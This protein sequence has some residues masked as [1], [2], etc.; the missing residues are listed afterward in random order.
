MLSGREKC[1]YPILL[2]KKKKIKLLYYAEL[3]GLP[4][5]F[6]REKPVE[7][8]WAESSHKINFLLFSNPTIYSA[9]LVKINSTICAEHFLPFLG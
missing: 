6:R 5:S 8:L 4:P 1:V 7:S 9:V 2:I 3:L